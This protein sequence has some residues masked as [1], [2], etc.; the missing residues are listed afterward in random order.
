MKRLAILLVAAALPSLAAADQ[1]S[2]TFT[3][4]PITAPRGA[5]DLELYS[6]FYDPAGASARG[7][8]WR[9]QVELEYG[10]TDRWDVSLYNV[11]RRPYGEP[12]EYEAAKLRTRFRLT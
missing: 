5:L 9:H 12:L 1:R 6:T 2:Y 11:F 7:R 3:Y 4:Q 10:I 8:G